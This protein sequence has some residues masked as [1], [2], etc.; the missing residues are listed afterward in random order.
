[1]GRGCMGNN[2]LLSSSAK[3]AII[4]T[5]EELKQRKV[6][7]SQLRKLEVQ[8]QG[9]RCFVSPGTFLLGLQMDAFL[10]CS[11]VAFIYV[12]FWCLFLF[13]LGHL[14]LGSPLMTSFNLNYLLLK[15]IMLPQLLI[16]QGKPEI[17]IFR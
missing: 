1:M 7:F 14:G 6:I 9:T 8:D 5:T 13:F 11:H 2:S 4:D 3:A 16:F 17:W 10:L 12:H 15:E